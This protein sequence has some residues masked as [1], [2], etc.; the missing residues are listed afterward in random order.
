MRRYLEYIWEQKRIY[1]IE[2]TEVLDLLNINLRGKIEVYLNACVLSNF[3]IFSKFPV[4]F[5]SNLNYIL[6]PQIFSINETI[7][8][9]EEHGQTVYFIEAGRVTLI[10]RATHSHIK[11]LDKYSVF[12]EIAF[13]TG[14]TR[15]TSIIT[16]DFTEVLSINR[17]DF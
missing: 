7:F 10:H 16:R 6:K 1:K 3:G 5:L 15:T 17:D 13:F 8:Y 11:E 14:K 2:E 4:E 9:E 12:G